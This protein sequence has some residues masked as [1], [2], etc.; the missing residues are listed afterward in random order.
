[1]DGER[2]APVPG[3]HPGGAAA[4]DRR[5]PTLSVVRVPSDDE[6][7]VE[8][9]DLGVQSLIVPVVDS[10]AEAEA[11][12]RSVACPSRG[13]ARRGCGARALRALERGPRLLPSARPETITLVVQA[14][15]AAAVGEHRGDRRGIERGR[16]VQWPLGPRRLHG[17]DRPADHRT[18]SPP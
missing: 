6:V 11:A 2:S 3:V 8:Y 17:A 14:E 9:L 7:V 1:M 5:L 15:S 10:V 16:R 13:C 18:S 12:A 4:R